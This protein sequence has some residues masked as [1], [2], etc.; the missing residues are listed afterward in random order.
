MFGNDWA[1]AAEIDKNEKI[2]TKRRI[3]ERIKCRVKN[4]GQKAGCQCTKV[5]DGIRS[6]LLLSLGGG[7]AG[8]NEVGPVFESQFP[9]E[10]ATHEQQVHAGLEQLRSD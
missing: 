5:Q 2:E 3:R 4:R 9:A 1:E 8:R 10:L 7:R 6:A